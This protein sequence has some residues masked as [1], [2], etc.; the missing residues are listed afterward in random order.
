MELSTDSF[1]PP[2]QANLPDVLLSLD[3]ISEKCIDLSPPP[4]P[5]QKPQDNSQLAV[6]VNNVCKTYGDVGATQILSNFSMKIPS[7]AM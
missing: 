3:N 6:N 5:P 7:G 4:T 1:H 2:I